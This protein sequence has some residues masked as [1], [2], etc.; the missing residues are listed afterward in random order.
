MEYQN[1]ILAHIT[2]IMP[3]SCANCVMS[4]TSC[5]LPMK[6]YPREDELLKPYITKRHKDCN[7]ILLSAV[8]RLQVD[9]SQIKK[10][11][12]WNVAKTFVMFSRTQGNTRFE[13]KP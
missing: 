7:L 6:S 13:S 9:L 10:F 1:K 2:D 4:G 8:E 11:I 5:M 12:P 3:D